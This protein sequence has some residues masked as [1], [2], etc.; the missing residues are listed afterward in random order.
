MD[1]EL[2]HFILEHGYNPNEG[3]F[4]GAA[5]ISICDKLAAII[6]A[7]LGLRG[8]A[9]NAAQKWITTNGGPAEFNLIENYSALIKRRPELAQKLPHTIAEI[10]AE[11]DKIC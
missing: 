4:G 8:N 2:E 7:K 3:Y 1:G 6:A 10:N 9:A 11:Y 5:E